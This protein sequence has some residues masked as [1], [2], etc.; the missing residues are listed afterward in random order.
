MD[1]QRITPADVASLEVGRLRV[2]LAQARLA[3]KTWK[4]AYHSLRMTLSDRLERIEQQLE[5]TEWVDDERKES[6]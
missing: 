4:A 6:E 5:A 2:E 1:L 3:A